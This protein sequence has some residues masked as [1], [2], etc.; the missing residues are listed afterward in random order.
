MFASARSNWRENC[1][2]LEIDDEGELIAT[3]QEQFEI[4][5]SDERFSAILKLWR[6]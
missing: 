6:E 1:K 4:K 5:P 2:N 3:L